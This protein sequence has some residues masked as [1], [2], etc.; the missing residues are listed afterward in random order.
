MITREQ[1]IGFLNGENWF[2]II[3]KKACGRKKSAAVVSCC[4][5]MEFTKLPNL[6]NFVQIST[7]PMKKFILLCDAGCFPKLEMCSCMWLKERNGLVFW[8]KG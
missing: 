2:C 6:S 5:S 3:I 7:M 1:V 8:E 4:L